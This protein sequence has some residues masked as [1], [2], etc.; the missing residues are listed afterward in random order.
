MDLVELLN[1]IRIIPEGPLARQV[2]S[3]T[4]K[5]ALLLI[6]RNLE[7]TMG[8]TIVLVEHRGL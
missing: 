6:P 2:G 3:C 5:K 4:I 8:T 7:T 1:G